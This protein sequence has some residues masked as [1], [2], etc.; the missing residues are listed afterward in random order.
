[1]SFAS[2]DLKDNA[3]CISI[4]I[5]IPSIETML[6][7]MSWNIFFDSDD[8]IVNPPDWKRLGSNGYDLTFILVHVL[9]CILNFLPQ[10]PPC[11]QNSLSAYFFH[12]K[13]DP[14]K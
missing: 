10:N 3:Q 12:N 11:H 6:A 2:D 4:H 1:M 5:L 7:A 9:M 8:N 13:T 14:E